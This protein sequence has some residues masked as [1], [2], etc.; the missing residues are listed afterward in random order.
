M[1][2]HFIMEDTKKAVIFTR[3]STKTQGES[4]LGLEAQMTVCLEWA[5]KHGYTVAGRFQEVVS[6]RATID[7]RVELVR[8]IQS[9]EK[10]VV[11]L[12]AKRD[13]LSRGD[14][15]C[16]AM[17]EKAVERKGAKI[18]SASGEGS[19]EEGGPSSLLIR[20]MIDAFSEYEALLISTRTKA[21]LDAK[22]TRGEKLG[23]QLPYGKTLKR[24][25]ITNLPSENEE[26]RVIEIVKRL[27]EQERSFHYIGKTLTKMGHRNRR[28]GVFQSIQVRRILTNNAF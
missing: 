26:Q 14:A 18:I 6:G 4:G 5:K 15:L 22:R 20:R 24:G 1:S 19:D 7:K 21:A 28:G 9:L 13:R 23:G 11:L 3:V 25:K 27:I 8:A 12:V 16:M 2:H 10:G 17:V